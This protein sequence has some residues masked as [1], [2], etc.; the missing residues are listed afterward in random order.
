LIAVAAVVC[1]VVVSMIL[2]WYIMRQKRKDADKERQCVAAEAV[3]LSVDEERKNLARD[4][5]DYIGGMISAAKLSANT[6]GNEPKTLALLDEMMDELRDIINEI[7]PQTLK[8]G[9]RPAVESF[10]AKIDKAEF[11]YYGDDNRIPEKFEI[12]LYRCARE[13]IN[14]AI[15]HSGAEKITVQLIIDDEIATLTVHDNGRGF[16]VNEPTSGTGLMNLCERIWFYNGSFN[17]F[18]EPGGGAEVRVEI[19]T[20]L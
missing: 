10:C 15:K 9:L 7:M 12:L 1:L 20:K 14:N 19:R 11:Y 4:L 13:L 5:H 18:S 2:V 8:F 16:D 6:P 17:V 3:L